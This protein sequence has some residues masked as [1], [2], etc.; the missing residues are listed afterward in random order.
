MIGLAPPTQPP[1]LS[2][3][4]TPSLNSPPSSPFSHLPFPNIHSLNT[5]LYLPPHPNSHLLL[6]LILS[7][8]ISPHISLPS[9]LLILTIFLPA[10]HHSH[11]LHLTLS[12]LMPSHIHY[13]S[14]EGLLEVDDDGRDLEGGGSG[15]GPVGGGRRK[16]QPTSQPASVCLPLHL[17]VI[18]SGDTETH[19][20]RLLLHLH[21]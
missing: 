5:L 13:S 4:C 7:S 12:T 3:H 10:C 20:A 1:S 2:C 19:S 18:V 14:V 16:G 21:N 8:L 6:S 11:C 15:R 17:V 9:F